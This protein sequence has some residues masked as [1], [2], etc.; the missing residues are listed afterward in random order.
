[1]IKYTEN[2]DVTKDYKKKYLSGIDAVIEKRQQELAKNRAEYCKD[3]FN[4]TEK[5]RSD[6][7]KMLGW[8]LV[9]YCDDLAPTAKAEKLFEEQN[10]TV[11]RMSFAILEGLEMSG[12]YYEIKGDCKRPLVLVQ[13]GGLGTPELVSGFYDGT[14]CNYNDMLERVLVRGVHVFAPQLLL[15]DEKKYDV[16]FDRVNID[17]RLKRCGSSITAVELYGLIKILDYFETKDNVLNFGMV[18]L[19]YGGFYTLFLS[20]IETR[21]KSAISCSYFSARDKYPFSDWVWQNS[22]ERFDDVEIAALTY[23][24]KL[25]IE[26]ADKDELFNVEYGKRSYEKLLS[27]CK[28]DKVDWLTFITFDGGHEFCKDDAPIDALVKHL[29]DEK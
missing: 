2:L 6:L 23:P 1:M 5:Y 9:D 17:A 25:C 24:R 10:Y 21:I 28:G 8:P 18:G 29:F 26:I 3:I 4:N 13:H 16:Q 22:A 12:L 11:Y 14:T 15:W 7:K 19:S 27:L 20:A